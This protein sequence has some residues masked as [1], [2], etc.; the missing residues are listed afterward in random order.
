ML[1]DNHKLNIMDIEYKGYQL[2]FEQA[3]G[4]LRGSMGLALET[5]CAAVS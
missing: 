3:L 1:F 5:L 2:Q 4:E